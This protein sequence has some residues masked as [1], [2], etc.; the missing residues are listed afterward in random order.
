MSERKAIP[1]LRSAVTTLLE[2]K[3]IFFP[4]CVIAFLQLLILEILY[5]APRYP[6]NTFFGPLIRRIWS[7]N[8][9]HYPFNLT[10]LPKFFQDVQTPVYIFVSSF[11]IA[12]AI[13]IIVSINN[14]KKV[15][16]SK[17]AKESW[18][19]YVHVVIASII[20]FFAVIAMGKV[21]GLVFNRALLISAQGGIKFWI[22]Q[23]ILLGAPTINFL[24]SIF[25][26]TVFAYVLPII[27]IDK[28]KIHSALLLN[29]KTLWG[30]FWFTFLVVLIP[31]LLYF[32]ILLLRSTTS[33]GDAM[34]DLRVLFLVLSIVVMVCIDAI[35]YCALTTHYLLGKEN[36]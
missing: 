32:P 31:S 6:L 3:I 36:S 16:M 29:F 7:E 21:F 2:H 33:L 30:S 15:E 27:V 17:I 26:A 24:I 22:K 4:F 35:I 11:L 5:F 1:L 23:V 20:I 9:L 10:L 14:D 12:M 18:G 28:K 8:Y 34:P 13:A 19:A 25:V